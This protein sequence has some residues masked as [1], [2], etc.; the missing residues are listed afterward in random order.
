MR[1]RL[2]PGLAC[3]PLHVLIA[4]IVGSKAM[5][6]SP[7][8]S[9]ALQALR[10]HHRL[11]TLLVSKVIADKL[12]R[13]AHISNRVDM[14]IRTLIKSTS[15]TCRHVS[16]DP[17]GTSHYADPP[18]LASTTALTIAAFSTSLTGI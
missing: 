8:R 13:C 6:S 15:R 7:N 4:G 17:Q 14:T 11:S 5:M 1:I 18:Q 16:L 3:Q 2:R 9:T 12:C 10:L